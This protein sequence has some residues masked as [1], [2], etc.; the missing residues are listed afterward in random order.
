MAAQPEHALGHPFASESR[1]ASGWGGIAEL[2]VPRK[3]RCRHRHSDVCGRRGGP[4]GRPPPY[5]VVGRSIRWRSSADVATMLCVVGGSVGSRGRRKMGRPRRRREDPGAQCI[6]VDWWWWRL[7]E[8][9]LEWAIGR[10][11]MAAGG[12]PRHFWE[13][14]T[15]VP[16]PGRTA[17]ATF[18]AGV[19]NSVSASV[20]RG[21]W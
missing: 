12:Q 17:G 18:P 8:A 11:N 15:R 6:G 1:T 21:E 7:G 13:V 14:D 3:P 4:V 19:R 20:R 10:L 9:S 16:R 5:S 2:G